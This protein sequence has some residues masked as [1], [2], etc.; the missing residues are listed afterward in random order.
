MYFDKEKE[1]CSDVLSAFT[2]LNYIKT[3]CNFH[4]ES[5]S[6]IINHKNGRWNDNF[7]R[8]TLNDLIKKYNLAFIGYKNECISLR[9]CNFEIEYFVPM[10]H[11]NLENYYSELY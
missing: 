5:F 1:V 6:I 2:H 9:S 3:S 4:R 10:S 11:F 7:G 8:K